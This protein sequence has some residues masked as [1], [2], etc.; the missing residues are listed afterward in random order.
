MVGFG[1]WSRSGAKYA[2]PIW[3][4]LVMLRRVFGCRWV[5]S[6]A[7]VAML[8]PIAACVDESATDGAAGVDGA[9]GVDGAAGV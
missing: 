8:L 5:S 2:W 1:L 4:G 6:L 7:V 3:G 9:P